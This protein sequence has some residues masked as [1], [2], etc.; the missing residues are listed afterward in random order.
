MGFEPLNQK[1][2]EIESILDKVNSVGELNIV[3]K[4]YTDYLTIHKQNSDYDIDFTVQPNIFTTVANKNGL[5]I[6][7]NKANRILGNYILTVDVGLLSKL[8]SVHYKDIMNNNVPAGIKLRN[9]MSTNVFTLNDNG[10]P[11]MEGDGGGS[12]GGGG[13][14]THSVLSN[15]NQT[16]N[17]R[18]KLLA[19]AYGIG[20]YSDNDASYS[21]YIEAIAKKRILGVFWVKYKTEID[22]EGTNDNGYDFIVETPWGVKSYEIPHLVSPTDR[23]N[24]QLPA[25]DYGFGTEFWPS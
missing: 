20:N 3:L 17:R 6:I 18:V 13:T 22:I 1:L 11:Y 8:L 21:A 16:T 5:Y 10:R 25:P 2:D 9:Y 19:H 24:F 4:H 23:S 12:S 7:G 14:T 15:T